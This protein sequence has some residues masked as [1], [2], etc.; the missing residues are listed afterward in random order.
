MNDNK[1]TLKIFRAYMLFDGGETPAEKNNIRHL[2]VFAK[3]KLFLSQSFRF[4][5]RNISF[6]LIGFSV[7]RFVYS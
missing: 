2:A 1:T 7:L 5:G 4:F 6:A 3:I